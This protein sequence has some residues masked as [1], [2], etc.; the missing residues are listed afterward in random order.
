LKKGNACSPS[1][2]INLFKAAIQ[3]VSF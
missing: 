2:E 1:L 3:P